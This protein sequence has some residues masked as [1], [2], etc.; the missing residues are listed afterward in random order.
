MI[1]EMDREEAADYY[2]W[3]S[4]KDAHTNT[5]ATSC[6]PAYEPGPCDCDAEDPEIV[7]CETCKKSYEV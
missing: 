6:A 1:I 2:V 5:C 4:G 3:K 7:I